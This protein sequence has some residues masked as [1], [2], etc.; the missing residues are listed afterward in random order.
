MSQVHNEAI[1]LGSHK[2][3][4]TK[5]KCTEKWQISWIS[6]EAMTNTQS[7]GKFHSTKALEL[8]TRELAA[9][10]GRGPRDFIDKNDFSFR[11]SIGTGH[12]NGIYGGSAVHSNRLKL[13]AGK[14]LILYQW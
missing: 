14:L 3:R 12:R 4:K 2:L 9:G 11:E 8:A 5:R 7:V 6:I 13:T 10:I 1:D